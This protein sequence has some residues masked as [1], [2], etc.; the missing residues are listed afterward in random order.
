MKKLKYLE[1]VFENC[2][3][4]K[5]PANLI[6]S[7]HF[8]CSNL[9]ICSHGCKKEVSKYPIINEGSIIINPKGCL[10]D[11]NWVGCHQNLFNRVLSYNDITQI[12]LHYSKRNVEGYLVEW[13]DGESDVDNEYQQSYKSTDGDLIIQFGKPLKEEA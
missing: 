11:Y 12:Y 1:L 2:E 7:L 5:I 13:K 8:N 10:F 4:V 6:S 9:S 3:Y